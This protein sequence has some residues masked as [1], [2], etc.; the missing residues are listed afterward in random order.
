MTTMAK[1]KNKGRGKQRK[2]AVTKA[3]GDNKQLRRLA[4][5][6][7]KS[8]PDS[9]KGRKVTSSEIKELRKAGATRKQLNAFRKK[10]Q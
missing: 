7:L 9:K 2:A 10:N 8:K 3:F 5:A 1:K 4:T 6:A